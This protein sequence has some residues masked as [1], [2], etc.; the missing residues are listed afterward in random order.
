MFSLFK[1]K[2]PIEKLFQQH[3]KLLKEAHALSTVNRAESDAKY[4]EAE[5][6]IQKIEA[7]KKEQS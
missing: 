2:T 7:L 6:L 4:E 3:K 1:K 5:A